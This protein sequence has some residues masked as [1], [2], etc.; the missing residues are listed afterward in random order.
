MVDSLLGLQLPLH[1]CPFGK[2]MA[3]AACR[4]SHFLGA[5]GICECSCRRLPVV[6]CWWPL[7]RTDAL[8]CAAGV[9]LV[10][11]TWISLPHHGQGWRSHGK[12][13]WAL[14]WWWC[15]KSHLPIPWALCAGPQMGRSLHDII[16][17]EC[18]LTRSSETWISSPASTNNKNWSPAEGWW[19]LLWLHVAQVWLLLACFIETSKMWEHYQ[20]SRGIQS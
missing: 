7:C 20:V 16:V 15:W 6:L 9:K 12:K 10:Q 19:D 17:L 13:L 4:L 14:A 11:S 5:W 3:L 2:E 18:K 1:C 8:L